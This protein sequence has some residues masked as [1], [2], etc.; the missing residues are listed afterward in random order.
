[1]RSD[2]SLVLR[3][4]E[5]RQDEVIRTK[6][7]PAGMPT[8]PALTPEQQAAGLALLSDPELIARI[9]RDV[10]ATGVVG[11]ASNALVAYLACV[12]RKLDKPLAILIQSTSAAG[13]S[14]LM[15]ALLALIPETE[16][17]HYS[18]MLGQSLFYLGEHSMKHKILAMPKKKACA[19]PAMR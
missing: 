8:T 3:A 11:E 2:L 14:T 12:S 19:R 17:V 9:G 5:Q 10:E 7:K 6:L 13:K 1:M 15:D 16:R 18:A 4:V